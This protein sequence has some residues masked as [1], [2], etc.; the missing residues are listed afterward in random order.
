MSVPQTDKKAERKAAAKGAAVDVGTQVVSGAVKGAA[1]GGLAGAG[2]GAA[3]GIG[4][5]VIK[6]KTTRKWLIIAAVAV[7]VLLVVV[8]LGLGLIS[9]FGITAIGTSNQNGTYKSIQ[10]SGIDQA[11]TNAAVANAAGSHVPWPLILA[12]DQAQPP[13]DIDK[14]AAALRQADLGGNEELGAGSVY[15]DVRTLRRPGTSDAQQAAASAERTA[16]VAALTSYGLDDSLARSVYTQALRW[17]L[18]QL[19]GCGTSPR[20]DPSATPTPTPTPTPSDTPDNTVSECGDWIA[21]SGDAANPLGPAYYI[22]SS[23]FG[24]RVSPG[25]GGSTYH[26]GLDMASACN[27]KIYAAMDGTVTVS[28]YNGTEG[29]HIEIEHPNGLTTQYMHMPITT[30]DGGP[31]RIVQVGDQVLA[32]QLIGHVGSTGASTGCHLHFGVKADGVLT[33]PV[34]IMLQLG[35]D[36]E[37]LQRGTK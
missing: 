8:P 7:A 32:G 28:A 18:G 37:A 27:T 24:P 10:A 22:I 35:I 13:V 36:L 30:A 19:N 12:V 5:A 26:R 15:D 20:P 3:K 23:R 25:N 21:V 31:G 16:Y 29:E 17:T 33:N 6:N 4:V 9:V 11:T 2:V 1:V 34:P 14:L